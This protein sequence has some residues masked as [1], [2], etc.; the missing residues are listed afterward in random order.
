MHQLGLLK[1]APREG[2]VKRD[3]ARFVVQGYNHEEGI[4]I[5][6]TFSPVARLKAFRMLCEFTCFKMFL[7]YG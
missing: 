4:D 1:Q 7:L 6:E 3:K 2:N 5:D